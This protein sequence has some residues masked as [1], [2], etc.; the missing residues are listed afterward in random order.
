MG[1]NIPTR[2]VSEGVT[3]RENQMGMTGIPPRHRRVYTFVPD[4]RR[5]C[6]GRDHN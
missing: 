6:P 5:A 3:M 2:S 1:R 4:F